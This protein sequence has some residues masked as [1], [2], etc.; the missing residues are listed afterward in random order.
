MKEIKYPEIIRV[1]YADNT[2][3]FVPAGID[4]RAHG[5]YFSDTQT[6]KVADQLSGTARARVILHEV[7]HAC[8]FHSALHETP[9]AEQEELIVDALSKQL[10][11]VF[12][13][14]PGLV[15]AL[16]DDIM[17]TSGDK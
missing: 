14:N 9:A 5:Y 11:C 16:M 1:G 3:K 2:L 17:Q 10:I 12:R 4:E 8:F 7:F 15:N 13:D 6:I